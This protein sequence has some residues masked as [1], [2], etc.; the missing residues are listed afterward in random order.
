V[1]WRKPAPRRGE[2]GRG[3]ER[4]EKRKRGRRDE[5]VVNWRI[6]LT[7][8]NCIRDRAGYLSKFGWGRRCPRPMGGWSVRVGTA[9]NER[10]GMG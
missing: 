2:W 8:S 3:D 10:R 9:A 4:K 1:E 7:E 5:E 6:A